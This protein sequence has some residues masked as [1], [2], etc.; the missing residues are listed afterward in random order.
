MQLLTCTAL[1]HLPMCCTQVETYDG[2][3]A[4]AQTFVSSSLALLHGEV[5]PTEKYMRVLRD[6]AADN[7]LDPLYQAWLSSIE[8][9]PSAGLPAAYFDTPSKYIAYCFLCIVALVVVGFFSQQ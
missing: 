1:L 9:V 3:R 4:K 2:W 5:K 8:T 6:G 7:Y